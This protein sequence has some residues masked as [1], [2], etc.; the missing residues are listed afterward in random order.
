MLPLV[1]SVSDVEATPIA[2]AKDP[3]MQVLIPPYFYLN[4]REK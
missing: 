3:S 4:E 2:A 1:T